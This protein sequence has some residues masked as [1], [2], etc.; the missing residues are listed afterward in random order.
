MVAGVCGSHHVSSGQRSIEAYN[1]V[2]E[3][4]T[5][6]PK[7]DMV[8]GRYSMTL[9]DLGNKPYDHAITEASP[10]FKIVVLTAQLQLEI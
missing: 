4:V 6:Y 9:T 2:S 7:G 1:R 5:T 10:S 8:Q 3:R